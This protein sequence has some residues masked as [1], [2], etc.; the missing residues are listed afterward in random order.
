MSSN[1]TLGAYLSDH[2]A[3]ATAAIDHLDKL[4][5]NAG[6]TPSQAVFVELARE[7]K[8]DRRTLEDLIERLGAGKRPIKQV[9]ASFAEKVGRLRFSDQVT[10]DHRLSQLLELEALQLGIEGKHAMWVALQ[11]VARIDP[12]L[13]GLDYEELMRRA[14]RQADVVERYRIEAATDAFA[15]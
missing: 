13:A 3:G 11:E 5:A 15:A 12:A 6:G 8:A 10:G 2:L 1:E 4:I 9:A 7:I 14:R